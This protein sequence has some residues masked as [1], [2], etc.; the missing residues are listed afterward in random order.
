MIWSLALRT[1]R[2]KFPSTNDEIGRGTVSNKLINTRKNE[3]QIQISP[4]L[5]STKHRRRG[6]PGSEIS[7]ERSRIVCDELRDIR[8][9][10]PTRQLKSLCELVRKRPRACGWH[11]GRRADK[12]PFHVFSHFTLIIVIEIHGE[13]KCEMA[14]SFHC[15]VTHPGPPLAVCFNI[16][17]HT[18]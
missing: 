15:E 12:S 13:V 1:V 18:P 11:R 16:L 10:H 14:Q 7:S 4:Y 5:P 17:P 3:T 6:V 9:R 8:R 2:Y